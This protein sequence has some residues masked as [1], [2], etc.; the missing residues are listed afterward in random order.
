[1]NRGDGW[2]GGGFC[3][4]GGGGGGRES[5]IGLEEEGRRDREEGLLA[6]R[7]RC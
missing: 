6:E 4:G 7:E 5:G 1:M 2:I 3:G